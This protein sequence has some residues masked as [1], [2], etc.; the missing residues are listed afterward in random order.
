MSIKTRILVWFLLPS[1]LI[2]TATIT[3]YHRYLHKTLNQNIFNQLEIVADELQEHVNFFLKEKRGRSAD[4]SSDGLIKHYTEEITMK[5]NRR[6]HYT[7]AL[8][9]HLTTNKM[10]LD[11][12]II[13]S[14]IVDLSG[15]IIS[16][17]K[18]SQIGKNV[19][20]RRYFSRTMKRGFYIGDLHYSPEFKQNTFEVC[21]LI[22]GKDEH[23]IGI[24]VNRYSGDS[25]RRITHRGTSRGP[26][27]EM[28]HEV[29]GETGELY[30]VNSNKIMITESRFVEPAILMQKVDTKGVRSA[31]DNGMGTMGIY[32]DYRNIPVLGVSRYIEDMDWVL[33]VEKNV[34]EAFAPIADLRNFTFIIG[35][36]G[37]TVIV[38]VAILISTGITR[39]INKLI[40]GTKRIANG[41]LDN[42]I[43]LGKRRDELN[44][45][46]ESF[47]LMMKELGESIL[48]NKQLFLLVKRGRDE[49]VKTF[50]AITDIITIHDK[51]FAILRANNTFFEKFNIN[52]R[53]LSSKRCH[54]IF[55]GNEKPWHSCPLERS[56]KSLKPEIEEID[57]PHMGG[58]FLVSVYPLKNETGEVYGFVHLAK[59]ITFQKKVERQLVEKAN[60]LKTVN[61]ELEDFVYIVSHDLKEPLFAIEGYTSRLLKTHKDS[62]DDKGKL[63]INR[64]KINIEKMSQKIQEI[65]EVLKV[66][67]IT[68]NFKNNDS[69]VIAREVVNALESKITKNRIN[70][71][72]QKDLPIVP[73]DENRM[74]DVLSNLLTNAIK[75][76][77]KDKQRQVKIGCDKNGNYYKFYVED[78]G[79]GIQEE[80]RE[81]IF[82]IFRRLKEV[83]TEGTGVGL[84]IVKKIVEQHKGN[85]WIEGPVKD[86][87]GSRFCFTM[88]INGETLG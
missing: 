45:L 20:Y 53:Q 71:S 21:N 2:T 4:F 18:D 23:P 37:I 83:E 35:I 65:M 76:M 64:T 77:G 12:D 40:E 32:T 55:H 78:T 59:D 33:L 51:D 67:R 15:R 8:N 75:F 46:G 81:Q 85:I 26:K 16:S 60:E 62:L 68:Y 86:G 39:P 80:Y 87:R 79:I 72:I 49:W 30:I 69:G 25:L 42:P 6:Q 7:T 56:K 54:E 36:A 41:N 17:T 74:K 66:G 27:V 29:L 50:D 48:E 28:R 70:V 61:K 10:P 14:F 34:L 44:H 22:V 38:T 3:F 24:I 58:N 13:E 31:L 19:S 73:C 1:I 82:K 52:K 88:P 57:D 11:H 84:A 47:N 63:Y 5:E 43:S 9:T